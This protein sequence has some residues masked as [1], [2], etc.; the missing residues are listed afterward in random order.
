[1][2]YLRRRSGY[3]LGLGQT[4]LPYTETGVTYT[5]IQMN[6]IGAT[7]T[8]TDTS[9]G[10]A[11]NPTVGD[12]YQIDITGGPP[13]TEVVNAQGQVVGTTDSDGNLTITTTVGTTAQMYFMTFPTCTLPGTEC[14]NPGAN[15]PVAIAGVNAGGSGV[16]PDPNNSYFVAGACYPCPNP[17]N[18]FCPG[19]QTGP[20]Q[21]G[22]SLMPTASGEALV[23]P[24]AGPFS[25]QPASLV[26]SVTTLAAPSA[27]SPGGATAPGTSAS[28]SSSSAAA[29]SGISI[30]WFSQS[31]FDSIPNW[32]LVAAASLLV[33]WFMLKD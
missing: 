1:M 19:Q 11:A 4:G 10:Y 8:G 20:V 17:V 6:N 26:P 2:A 5:T 18:G 12:G 30:S 3:F 27:L 33:G 15:T 9:G 23:A 24:G 7:V 29:G 13:N 31:M 16:C 21:P 14:Q 32:A 25:G 28:S 22:A